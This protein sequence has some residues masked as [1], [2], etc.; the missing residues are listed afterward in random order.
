MSISSNYFEANN[1]YGG[2]PFVYMRPALHNGTAPVV[3][4]S[5]DIVLNGGASNLPDLQY[6]RAYVPRGV[7]IQGNTHAP[8]TNGSAVFAVC[9]DGLVLAGNTGNSARNVALIETGQDSSMFGVKNVF[10]RANSGFTATNAWPADTKAKATPDT[11][12]MGG[13]LRLRPTLR[14][15]AGGVDLHTWVLEDP[16]T[17]FRARNYGASRSHAAALLPPPFNPINRPH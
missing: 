11:A 10:I 15:F 12:D 2:R 17:L 6:G 8:T 9:A 14:D 16:P 13:N 4:I 5:S 1:G 7:L 3:R